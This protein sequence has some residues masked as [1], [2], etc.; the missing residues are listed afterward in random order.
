MCTDVGAVAM[1]MKFE[2]EQCMDG[3]GA[4]LVA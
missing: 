1:A 2:V 3:I 4:E